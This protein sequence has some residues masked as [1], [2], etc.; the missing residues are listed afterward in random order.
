M[1]LLGG[2]VIISQQSVLASF[3]CTLF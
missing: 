2:L 3:I 1:A